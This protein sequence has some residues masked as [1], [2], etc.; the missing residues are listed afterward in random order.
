[1]ACRYLLKQLLLFTVAMK[2]NEWR[3][4]YSASGAPCLSHNGKPSQLN[5]SMSH[6]AGWLAIGVAFEARIGVDIERLKPRGNISAI[7][8]FLGWKERIH[9]NLDFHEKWTMWEAS[10]K[11]VEGSVF[12][13]NN[14]GFERLCDRKVQDQVSNSGQWSSLHGCLDEKLFYAIVLEGQNDTALTHRILDPGTI[15]PW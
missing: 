2:K 11:S 6:S 14:P 3:L 10:A 13:R 1:M 7:A 9:D 5:V 8:A 4:Y 15:E 12:M